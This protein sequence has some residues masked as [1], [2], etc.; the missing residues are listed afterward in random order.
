M[1]TLADI[2]NAATVLKGHIIRTPLVYSPTFS[3]MT[4]AHVYLKLEN[5]QKAGSFK[6]RGATSK[7]HA[8][9]EQIGD[10]GVIAAS[11]GNH[12]QGVAVAAR[13][14]GIPATIVMPETVSISKE[15]A[16][17]GYGAEVILKGKNLTE[18]LQHAHA[19]AAEGRVFIHPFNDPDV[20][21]GQGTIAL[22]ILDDL[23]ETDIVIV[24]VGGGGLIGG[25]A[26]GAKALNPGI[27]IIGVETVACPAA[28]E[29]RKAG[30]PVVVETT[31]SIADGIM[32]NPVGDLPF[33]IMQEK[34]DDIIVID[35]DHITRTM[36]LLLE[37][38]KLLAEGAGVV[39]LAALLFGGV[40]VPEGSHV[41]V[42]IS[43]GNMDLP[44]VDRIIR[45]GLMRN[46]R[47]MQCTVQIED[48]PGALARLLAVIGDLRG[49]IL[50]IQHI[51]SEPDLPIN[52]IR[53][54]LDI[55][56]RNT[57][58]GKMIV[59]ALQNAGYVL[60]KEKDK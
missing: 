16:T 1:V 27:R 5:L 55:E 30:K 41:V 24:P 9:R 52:I 45:Q 20:I 57:E 2:Q 6:V 7:I 26:A 42:V 28:Y 60:E 56:T 46:G 31:F 47:I 18:S 22:E 17:F 50:T 35:E 36:L 49:N 14:A 58:H 54:E 38:K 32:V 29:A 15:E 12:A 11:A 4:G 40:A 10:A 21:A 8:A 51:R 59:D 37:R 48:I 23:P 44:L 3:A 43:G 25:I 19:L 39:G 33:S 34:V 53:V 13:Q